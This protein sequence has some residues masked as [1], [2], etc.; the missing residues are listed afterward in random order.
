LNFYKKEIG[1]F[2][3]RL[4]EMLNRKPT[5]ELLRELEQYQNQFIRQKEVVD[6]VNHKIHLYDDELKG[7]PAEIM[8]PIESNEIVKHKELEDDIHITRKLYF[9]LRDRFSSYLAKF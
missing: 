4:T 1:I 2:E 6:Q 9:D 5:R 7:I 8:L 3:N